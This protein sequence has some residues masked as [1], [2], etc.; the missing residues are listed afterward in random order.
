M[1]TL[2]TPYGEAEVAKPADSH[3]RVSARGR[4]SS[5]CRRVKWS[6]R[7]IS[8]LATTW[9]RAWWDNCTR[10]RLVA[11]KSAARTAGRIAQQASRHQRDEQDLDTPECRHHQQAIRKNTSGFAKAYCSK[12]RRSANAPATTPTT[13]NIP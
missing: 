4:R 2:S 7:T 3:A 6:T 10:M 13:K 5:R 12:A 8:A 11:L 9:G 1:A